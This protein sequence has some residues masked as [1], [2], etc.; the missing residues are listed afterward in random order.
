[1]IRGGGGEGGGGNYMQWNLDLTKCQGTG[2]ICSLSRV[3][4]IE[5]L[6]ITNMWKNNQNVRYIE[7][8][9][10]TQYFRNWTISVKNICALCYSILYRSVNS[11]G[12]GN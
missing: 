8:C 11:H 10:T 1:M 6:D 3:R 5:N 4:Y 2:E 9:C 7:V 12:A